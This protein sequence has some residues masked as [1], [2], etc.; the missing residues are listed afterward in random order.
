MVALAP[1][2]ASAQLAVDPTSDVNAMVEAL[3]ARGIAVVTAKYEAAGQVLWWSLHPFSEGPGHDPGTG[4]AAIYTHGPLGLRDGLLLTSGEVTLAKPPNRSLPGTVS[5]EGATGVLTPDI[6]PAKNGNPA[7]A[8]CAGLIGASNINPH[9]VVKLT[10]DFTLDPGYDGIQLDYVFGS[11]EYPDYVGQLYPDAFGFF[12][13]AAG[14]TA[15]TNFGRDPEGHDIDINGPFFSSQNVIKT[16]GPGA[17]LGPDGQVLSEYNGLTPHLRSAFPLAAGSDKIHRVVIVIC[18][19]GDQYLD[20]GVFLTALAGCQGPCNTTT[21]CGDGQVQA[22]EACDDGD[23]QGGDGCDSSCDVEPGWACTRPA[24]GPSVCSDQCGDGTIQPP[25]ETCDDKNTDTRDDCTNGCQIATCSDGVLHDHGTGSETGVDCGG[26]CPGCPDGD[27]CHSD[28]DCLSGF[29]K[30]PDGICQPAP[31]TEARDD[32]WYVLAGEVATLDLAFFLANDKDFDPDTFDPAGQSTAGATVGFDALTGLVSYTPLPGAHGTDTFTYEVCNPYVPTQCD[33]AVVTVHINRPPLVGDVET[34]TSV[35]T[36]EVTLPLAAWFTDPDGDALGEASV[37]GA[38]VTPDG[39]LL[40]D[41][42]PAGQV[43]LPIT[44]CDAGQPTG[45]D[46]G[47]WTIHVNDPPNVRR[48][49]VQLANGSGTSIALD[50]YLVDFGVVKGDGPADGDSDGL[51]PLYIGV[52]QAGPFGLVQSIG[53]A[54]CSIDSH[55]GAVSLVSSPSLTGVASCWVRVCEELP[56]DDPAVCSI[57]EIQVTVVPCLSDDDCA[58]PAPLC[59]L[60]SHTCIPCR[61][62]ETGVARD[63]GCP[64][65]APMCLIGD[66]PTRCVP[67]VD[68]HGAGQSDTGCGSVNNAC[69][70]ATTNPRC[71]DCQVTADCAAGNVCEPQTKTCVPCRDT[72]AFPAVDEGCQSGLP[73][74]RTGGVTTPVCVECLNDGQCPGGVCDPA[75]FTC[76]TC[77]DTQP[78]AGLDAGCSD[79]LPMCDA[80]PGGAGESCVPCVDDHASPATDT[81]CTTALP[82]C[83]TLAAG[84][85]RCVE[86]ASDLDC[87]EARPLCEPKSD[88]CVGCIGDGDCGDDEICFPG[89]HTCVDREHTQAVD[90]GYHTNQGVVL[91]VAKS[92][93]VIS[94]DLVPANLGTPSVAIVAGTAPSAAQGVL[95]LAADGS[96]T[97]TPADAFH[98]VVTFRYALS[99]G[100]APVTEATVTIRVNG[101]P[102]PAPDSGTT[103]MNAAVALPVTDNDSDPEG[104][105]LTITAIPSGPEHGSADFGEARIIYT[106]DPDFSGSDSFTYEVCDPDGACAT[107]TVTVIVSD[108]TEPEPPRARPDY[109]ETDEDVPVLIV[110]ASNDDP[111]LK[112]SHVE[113]PPMHGATELLA[114]GTILY[115]PAAD[116][117]G[118]DVFTYV[119]CAGETCVEVWV[120]V[121]VAPLNDPPVA[122]DDATGTPAATPVTVPVRDNDDDPDGDSLGNPAVTT[123]PAHGTTEIQNGAVRYTPAA[124]YTGTDT[125]TYSVCD[126]QGA[127]DDAIVTI[128]VGDSGP[129]PT[130]GD[131]VATTPE[132]EP[133]TIPVLDNDD[134]GL[135]LS[136]VCDPLHGSA[137]IVAGAVVYTPDAGFEGEDHFCYT[138]CADALCD[139]GRVTV[140]VTPTFDQPPVALDDYATTP[141]NTPVAVHPLFNDLDPEGRALTLLS[142]APPAHGTVEIDGATLTYHP[143]AGYVGLDQFEVAITDGHGTATSFVFITVLPVGNRP[144]VADDDR[145]TVSHEVGR[146]LPVR[147]ND[148]DPDGE[149]IV[150]SYITQPPEGTVRLDPAGD[151]AYTPTPLDPAHPAERQTFRYAVADP[152]GALDDALVT[153][154]LGD[155]DG[156]GLTDVYEVDVSFTDPNDPDTDNDGL[157]DGTEVD[158]PTDPL[159]ADSDDDGISDG[160]EA[161]GTTDPTVCDSDADGLCDGLESGVTD[162]VAPGTSEG[163]IPYA[164]TD[165]TNWHPDLD[166]SSKTDPTDDDTDDDGLLD[167]SEDENGDGAVGERETDPNDRDSDDDLLLDG[168]ELG[169]D[170]PEGEDTDP[171]VFRADSDPSTTTDPLDADTD[172]GTVPDGTEDT[173]LNVR[174]DSG[175]RDPNFA[176]D[177]VPNTSV[178]GFAAFGGGGCA[179]ASGADASGLAWALVAALL[180]VGGLGVARRR[181]DVR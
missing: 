76:M 24:T 47:S 20:S 6:G 121:H 112:P 72:A 74:C 129:L 93:G 145:Y 56:V 96:L 75:T 147:E 128:T 65:S 176:A 174:F 118:P 63:P 14:D 119:T 152:H 123:T 92:S 127:C 58:D 84:G 50:R 180:T 18:D 34:W 27:P 48:V 159:D 82:T 31:V 28:A 66:G 69:D 140:T 30:L 105:V 177:D 143:A 36:D 60:G 3:I 33:T 16:Y 80:P 107:T 40:A 150:F 169:L 103:V 111:S 35:G 113:R 162:P 98:G 164:G 8:F 26:S 106:P 130:V 134:D 89:T 172:D 21:W 178:E 161:H 77:R 87:P 170:K 62:T 160:D 171:A 148:S 156:D 97:F 29:C 155:S 139:T 142:A 81:G 64:A 157:D 116:W 85:P 12:V 11:E 19:A 78:G 114:D 13:R 124:G 2:P 175:V 7:E 120:A 151:L 108:T 132:G 59:D 166:P 158:G 95:A 181:R 149:P 154:E 117:H 125:F 131:D 42:G 179:G 91:V 109:A 110:V 136:E 167:G 101:A 165:T 144:P 73:I 23:V 141:V 41:P 135:A 49:K 1:A 122:R 79:L 54:S 52:G 17:P 83:D 53:I 9:D 71:V 57:A 94:N 99:A 67:C 4:P 22:G 46:D 32:D 115:T 168:T 163:G 55:T 88:V 39:T 43:T 102:T 45:C 138:A 61:D 51:A 25:W 153:L 44:A 70:L 68:D 173:N 5:R 104:D 38:L 37:P 133:V 15:F 90:D 137:A 100:P 86:C 146:A 10:I 126:A